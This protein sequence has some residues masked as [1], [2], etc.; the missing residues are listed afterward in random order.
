Q[1]RELEVLARKNM[2]VFFR[3]FGEMLPKTFEGVRNQYMIALETIDRAVET[4]HLASLIEKYMN[5]LEDAEKDLPEEAQE[6]ARMKMATELT[7]TEL[8]GGRRIQGVVLKG[9]D[10]C[11]ALQIRESGRGQRVVGYFPLNG[12]DLQPLGLA[13]MEDGT[14]G[15]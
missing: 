14:I 2:M 13:Q 9:T 1:K 12:Y 6:T 10:S 7:C 8:A 5:A 15:M 4:E 11:F 3:R